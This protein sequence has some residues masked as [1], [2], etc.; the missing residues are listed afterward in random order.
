MGLV[1]EGAADEHRL[2]QCTAGEQL[3]D[4]LIHTYHSAAPGALATALTCSHE[5][6]LT[7]ATFALESSGNCERGGQGQR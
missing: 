1:V 4:D 5:R 6:Q 3:I 7:T 2:A